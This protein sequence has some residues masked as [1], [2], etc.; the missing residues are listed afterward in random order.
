MLNIRGGKEAHGLQKAIGNT[1]T[2]TMQQQG[3]VMLRTD[4]SE[5]GGEVSP[6]SCVTHTAQSFQSAIRSYF[7]LQRPWS[8]TKKGHTMLAVAESQLQACFKSLQVDSHT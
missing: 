7:T 2:V 1:N 8:M 4:T 5:E 3:I 6:I